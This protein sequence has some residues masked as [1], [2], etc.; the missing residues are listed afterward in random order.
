MMVVKLLAGMLLLSGVARAQA[1]AFEVASIRE[2]KPGSDNGRMLF[3]DDSCTIRNMPLKPVIA[4]VYGVRMDLI[5]GL[6]GWAET[7]RFDIEA[8]ED[9]ETVARLKK[10]PN[11]ERFAQQKIMMKAMLEDR[12]KLKAATV[13]KTLPDYD[14]VVAKGGFKLKQADPNNDYANGMKTPEGKTGAKGMMMTGRG[15]ITAQAIELK[16][17]AENLSYQVQRSV[18]DK[19]GLTG[20]YDFVLKWNPNETDTN[21]DLPDF[22]TAIEEQ[23]GLKLV[24][25]K[26]PSMTLVVNSVAKPDGN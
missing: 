12:F 15:Q 6:P 2:S 18:V 24:P 20:K 1:P 7:M 5:S 13:E 9:E 25:G 17:L 23:M 16:R 3:G 8:K 11:E 26:G 19:T 22:F 4:N 21:S 14:M 10:L